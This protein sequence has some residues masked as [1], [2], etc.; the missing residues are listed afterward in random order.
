MALLRLLCVLSCQWVVSGC[1]VLSDLRAQRVARVPVFAHAC[2]RES[3]PGL[4]LP[5]GFGSVYQ[6]G[7]AK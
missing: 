2:V 4:L 1:Q 6:K 7:T 3:D 5:V